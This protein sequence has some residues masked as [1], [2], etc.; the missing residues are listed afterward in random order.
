ML[1]M[2]HD[3]AASSTSR[4]PMN[5]PE[6]PANTLDAASTPRPIAA[7]IEAIRLCRWK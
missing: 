7:T 4:N 5:V 2:A 1:P 6:S 3:S